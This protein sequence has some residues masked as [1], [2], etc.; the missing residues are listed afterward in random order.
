M[1]ALAV[2]S[3]RGAQVVPAA[4][5]DLAATVLP[6]AVAVQDGT[7]IADGAT[8]WIVIGGQKRRFASSTLYWA[9]GYTAAMEL[10]ASAADLAAVPTGAVFG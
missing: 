7:I 4:S 5:G 6:G 3:R 9:M 1:S 10:T 8:P 2:A